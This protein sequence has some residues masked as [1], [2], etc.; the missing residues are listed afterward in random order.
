MAL[1]LW[2]MIPVVIV[3]IIGYPAGLLPQPVEGARSS[4][5][6]PGWNGWSSS[7]W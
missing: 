4:G 6:S 3:A 7:A 2:H 1:Y 5:G